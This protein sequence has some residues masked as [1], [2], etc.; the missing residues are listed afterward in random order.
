MATRIPVGNIKPGML[1]AEPILNKQQREIFPTGTK[2]T[3]Y[4]MTFFKN[5]G[6][7]FVVIDQNVERPD[8]TPNSDMRALAIQHVDKRILWKPCNP[9]EEEIYRLAIQRAEH[10]L[11]ERRSK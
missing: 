2:L 11:V 1:L 4:H 10:S 6:I 3:Q 5:S 8:S 9:L 7:Q